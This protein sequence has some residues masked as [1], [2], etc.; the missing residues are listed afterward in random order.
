MA[1]PDSHMSLVISLSSDIFRRRAEEAVKTGPQVNCLGNS[2]PQD[3][4]IQNVL[5]YTHPDPDETFFWKNEQ[6]ELFLM[7]GMKVSAG[8]GL[9][10]AHLRL[11]I[12][13][14]INEDDPQAFNFIFEFGA[15]EFE[16]VDIL[17]EERK[18]KLNQTAS[19]QLGPFL[20]DFAVTVPLSALVAT[21]AQIVDPPLLRIPDVDMTSTQRRSAN[22]LV[23]GLEI[24][25]D[26]GVNRDQ[27]MEE[28]TDNPRGSVE[29]NLS[30]DKTL[31]RARVNEALSAMDFTQDAEDGVENWIYTEE[32]KA[33]WSGDNVEGQMMMPWH[34]SFV[35]EHML[36]HPIWFKIIGFYNT[37]ASIAVEA[38]I[39]GYADLSVAEDDEGIPQIMVNPYL[40]AAGWGIIPIT[41]PDDQ[42]PLPVAIAPAEVAPGL[43][44]TAISF[45]NRRLAFDGGDN[46]PG[47]PGNA[48][49]Q[50][51]NEL[52]LVLDRGTIGNCGGLSTYSQEAHLYNETTVESGF[53]LTNTGE[54]PLFICR[55]TLDDPDG[56][57]SIAAN[58]QLPVVLPAGESV[59][60]KL[61]YLAP[62]EAAHSGQLTLY[63]N[64]P[65]KKLAIIALT[66]R[67]YGGYSASDLMGIGCFEKP[68][69]LPPQD[70]FENMGKLLRDIGSYVEGTITPEHMLEVH[71]SGLSPDAI[72]RVLDKG[73]KSIAESFPFGEA[74]YVSTPM[75]GVDALKIERL[76]KNQGA[77]SLLL[78][79]TH[80]QTIGHFAADQPPDSLAQDRGYIYAA[81]P[82][83]VA[84]ISIEEP[85]KPV[86]VAHLPVK[87]VTTT[88]LVNQHLLVGTPQNIQVYDISDPHTP[89]LH[90]RMATGPFDAFDDQVIVGAGKSIRFY[91]IRPG[92]TPALKHTL[93]LPAIPRRLSVYRQGKDIILDSDAASFRVKSLAP[94]DLRKA[95]RFTTMRDLTPD[96]GAH[97]FQLLARANPRGGVDIQQHRHGELRLRIASISNL[98]NNQ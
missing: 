49:L 65:T 20:Q 2:D 43:T 52:S 81:F 18:A 89:S 11:G 41:I 93:K 72:I 8:E 29:W 84:I 56:V 59:L 12:T 62:D 55:F 91:T 76:G 68:E 1:L 16:I 44:V 26:T 70:W 53:Y 92:E 95:K 24:S 17:N 23:V 83:R 48:H 21:N 67:L 6:R 94:K 10:N 14:Q 42:Q 5:F 87:Q 64:D 60:L 47:L 25:T 45:N 36:E 34:D 97:M 73:G 28:F 54:A 37:S 96:F 82:D 35:A 3:E 90:H 77:L 13:A 4:D 22:T 32:T 7:I 63:C 33:F 69:M 27:F 85:R 31:M 9:L 57:F 79:T 50:V 74:A 30:V 88:K 40:F 75:S 66:G 15:I 19:A 86:E 71:V 78:T 61:R 39:L 80:T 38:Y 46:H 58:A 51:P 98:L